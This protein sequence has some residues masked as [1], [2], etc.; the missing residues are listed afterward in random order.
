MDTIRDFE[1]FVSDQSI[2]ERFYVENWIEVVARALKNDIKTLEELYDMSEEDF[3]E[4]F[5]IAEKI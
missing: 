5:K 2:D 3:W 1:R 4:Y